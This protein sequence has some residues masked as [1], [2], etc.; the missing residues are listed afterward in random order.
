MNR[1]TCSPA[2]CDRYAGWV[3]AGGAVVIAYMV[4]MGV[5]PDE[6]VS[7]DPIILSLVTFIPAIGGLLILLIPRRDRD[8]KMFRAGH[9]AAGVVASLHLPV[10]LH[11]NLSGLSVRDRQALDREPQYPLPHGD[12]RNLASGSW[13]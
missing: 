5:T 12:R 10:H 13:C 1:A 11:R 7:L 4:W 9:L 8:I 2:T 3:A 6:H